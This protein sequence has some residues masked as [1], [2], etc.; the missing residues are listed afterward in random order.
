MLPRL[1]STLALIL[2]LAFAACGGSDD[3][4]TTT[5]AADAPS[6]PA[7]PGNADP[8]DVQVIDSW[9]RALDRNDIE[10][11]AGYFALPSSTL[12]GIPLQI[13][14]KA[15]ARAFNRS[16]PCGARLVRATAN[17]GFTI[18]TFRLTERPGPGSCGSGAGNKAATAF[19]IDGGEIT[20]WR[21]VPVPGEGGGGATQAPGEST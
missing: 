21:R 12:N 14:T 15:D 9:A 3:G 1:V 17:G 13:R 11:A 7:V 19:A 16:L 18:A 4:D 8:A 6:A 10:A 20:D 2:A 5:G